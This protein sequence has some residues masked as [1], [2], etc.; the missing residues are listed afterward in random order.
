M[1]SFST[2]ESSTKSWVSDMTKALLQKEKTNVL[3]I[4]WGKGAVS[5]VTGGNSR[6]VGAQVAYILKN[7][8]QKRKVSHKNV[9]VIGFSLGAHIAGFS[10]KRLIKHGYKLGRITGEIYY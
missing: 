9:H 7:V 2:P 10:G 1:T 6:L 8:F 4:D 3:V 5:F